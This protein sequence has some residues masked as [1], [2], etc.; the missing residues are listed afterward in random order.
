[1]TKDTPVSAFPPSYVKDPYVPSHTDPIGHAAQDLENV[2]TKFNPKHPR[3]FMSRE[4]EN[5]H[6]QENSA[7]ADTVGRT[8]RL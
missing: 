7:A 1:V 2:K 4:G 6:T 3:M 5:D 8:R